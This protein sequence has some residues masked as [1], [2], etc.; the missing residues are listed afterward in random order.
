[1]IKAEKDTFCVLYIKSYSFFVKFFF[2]GYATHLG[3][4]KGY[5][6]KKV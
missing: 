5:V 4:A 6:A 3:S 1:M 2:E